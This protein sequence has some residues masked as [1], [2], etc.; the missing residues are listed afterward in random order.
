[1]NQPQ[2]VVAITGASRGIGLETARLFAA[3]GWIVYNLSRRPADEAGIIDIE[4]DVTDEA[5]VKGAFA[6]IKEE[7]SRLDLLINNAGYGISGAAEYTQLADAKRQFDVNFFGTLSCIQ[8]AL[9]LLRETKGRIICI[10]SAAAV[11]AIPFQSF[12]SATKASINVLA[13]SL[14]NEL[15]PFGVSICALQLGDVKTDFT[16]SRAKSVAGDDLYGGAIARSVAVMEKDEQAGITP[17]RIAAAIYRLAIRSRV[18][19]LY[20]LG[21]KYQ[22]FVLLNKLLPN[23]FVNWLVGQLYVR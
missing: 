23:S 21:A 13:N 7:N 4:C 11:F 22:L 17:E 9:P 10:S 8:A 3:Q 1:M 5:A 12:Y 19:P 18:K 16:K 15:K 14:A 20:T 2:K 6:R